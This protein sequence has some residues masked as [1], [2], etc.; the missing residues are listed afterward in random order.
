MK[1]QLFP[2]TRRASVL[3]SS[4]TDE[5]IFDFAHGEMRNFHLTNVNAAGGNGGEPRRHHQRARSDSWTTTRDEPFRRRQMD[6][7]FG[8]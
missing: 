5:N 4:A 7:D 1:I 3:F 2:L 6:D 8:V